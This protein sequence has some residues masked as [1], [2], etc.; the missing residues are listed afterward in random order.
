MHVILKTADGSYLGSEYKL[1]QADNGVIDN[2]NN[3][4]KPISAEGVSLVYKVWRLTELV[5]TLC[6]KI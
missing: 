6:Y 1:L 5:V 2:S 3:T 4:T